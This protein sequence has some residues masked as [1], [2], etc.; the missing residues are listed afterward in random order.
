MKKLA[1][2][3]ALGA[4]ASGCEKEGPAE[5]AGEKLDEAVEQIGDDI[6]DAVD[7]VEEK[8]EDNQ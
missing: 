3:I 4:L 2:L 8:L 1:V 6:D 7:E 5:Q